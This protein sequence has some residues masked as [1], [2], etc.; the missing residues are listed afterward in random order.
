VK[1]SEQHWRIPE[2]CLLNPPNID[3]PKAVEKRIHDE[4]VAK[5]G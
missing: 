2:G 3:D 4:I 1:G 5:G